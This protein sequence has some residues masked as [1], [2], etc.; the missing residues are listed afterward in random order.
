MP[1][2]DNRAQLALQDAQRQAAAAGAN[3]VRMDFDSKVKQ[4]YQFIGMQRSPRPTK[5]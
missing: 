2:G 3:Q 5:R 4:G 1:T